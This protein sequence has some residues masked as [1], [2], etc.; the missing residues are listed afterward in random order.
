[1]K[2]KKQD[3]DAIIDDTLRGIRDER[4]DESTIDESATRVWA[5]VS[6]QLSNENSLSATSNSENLNTM[7]INNTTEHI[8]GCADF[9]S[10]IPAYLDKQ[11]START[12]LL[13]D[14]A[15]ECIPCRRA[16]K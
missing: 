3:L 14:H 12:L 5:R 4:L 13:E 10:L 6:E 9:Q 2:L 11:L 8:D 7:N 15:N 1:M 16:L